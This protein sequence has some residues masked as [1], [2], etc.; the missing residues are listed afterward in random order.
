MNTIKFND[1][2][3]LVESYNRTTSFAGEVITSTGYCL[4]FTDDISALEAL[5]DTTITS[6]QIYH[7]NELI[8]NLTDASVHIENINEYLNVDKM[9]VNVNLIFDMQ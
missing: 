3:F 2:T 8:Y 7:D 5:A 1:T 4:I 9:F 6:I